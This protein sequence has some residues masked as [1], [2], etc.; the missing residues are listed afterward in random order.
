VLGVEDAFGCVD[1]QLSEHALALG[2]PRR[3]QIEPVQIEQVECVVEQPVLTARGEVGVQQSEIRN[4]PRIRDNGFAI[5]D[6]VVSRQ[7][8]ERIS[9]RL[10]ALRPVVPARV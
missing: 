3:A 8:C 1:Q 4:A 6:Q 7:G 10:E 9:D 2:K 5:Q